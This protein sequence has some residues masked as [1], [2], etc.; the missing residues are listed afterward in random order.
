LSSTHP[1]ALCQVVDHQIDKPSELVDEDLE[2]K[3]F[4]LLMLRLQ[5]G[6]LRHERSFTRWSED[7]RQIAGALEEKASIPMVRAE[8]ELIIEVQTDEFWQDITALMLEDV[9]KRLRSLVK[10]IEKTKRQNI[11]TDFADLIGEDREIDLPGFAA[12]HDAERF[13]D[14]TQQFLRMHESDPVI[15]KLRWNEP[16]SRADLDALEKI[17]VAAG[18]G[19]PDDLSKVRSGSGLGLFVREMIG[20]DREAAKRA[21]DGFLAG[22]TLT[23]N[24]IQWSS[25]T[26]ALRCRCRPPDTLAESTTTPACTHSPLPPAQPRP[27]AAAP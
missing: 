23:A 8:L 3:Q 11:Y 22:K 16:L 13:R 15:H 10:F 1:A 9:R 27:S 26:A 20:L 7:V 17:L 2:A 6:L 19:T 5:L 21:F 18:A 4:D 25:T 12:G 14:K 24:Q